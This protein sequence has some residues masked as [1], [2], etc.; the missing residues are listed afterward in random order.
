MFSFV[1]YVVENAHSKKC[2]MVIKKPLQIEAA[3][4]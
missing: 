4:L 3:Y 1:P 2:Q